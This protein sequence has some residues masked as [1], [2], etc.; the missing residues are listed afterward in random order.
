MARQYN[1]IGGGAVPGI[2]LVLYE[3]K[4]RIQRQWILLGICPH[5]A[6]QH[7]PQRA[8]PLN[9][10]HT[11]ESAVTGTSCGGNGTGCTAR[12]RAT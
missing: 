5:D 6:F 3:C 10:R 12:N 7:C 11:C 9:I 1:V 4:E 2:I 8:A